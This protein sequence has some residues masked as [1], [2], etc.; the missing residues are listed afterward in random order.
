MIPDGVAYEVTRILEQNIQYGTGPPRTS[1]GRRPARRARPSN[2]ADAWFC[3]YT[4]NLSTT[5]WVGYPQRQ[6]P[7]EYVHGIPVAGGTFPAVIWG[8]YMR[9]A[10]ENP[11]AARVGGADGVAGLRTSSGAVRDDSERLGL[12]RLADRTSPDEPPEPPP[13]PAEDRARAHACLRPPPVPPPPPAEPSPPPPPPPAEPPPP[14]P[15][16]RSSAAT[17]S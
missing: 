10:L 14:R 12:R 11:P 17:P 1:A 6:I 4:P 3:G 13:P 7:M 9:A 16:R 15:S 8:R 5:V 2:H